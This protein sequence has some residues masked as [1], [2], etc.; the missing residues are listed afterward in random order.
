MYEY[1]NFVQVPAQHLKPS[2]SE[3]DWDE[4][5]EGL[6]S[7]P[8]ASRF[9]YQCRIRFHSTSNQPDGLQT[10]KRGI[11]SFN[12]TSSLYVCR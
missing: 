7:E 3:K 11:L 5:V 6:A 10:K 4:H 8:P 2:F 1:V 12:I 9:Y